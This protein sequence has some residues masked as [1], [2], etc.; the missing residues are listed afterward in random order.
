MNPSQENAQPKCIYCETE[1]A[2]TAI[3][4][5]CTKF[6]RTEGWLVFCCPVCQRTQYLSFSEGWPHPQKYPPSCLVSLGDLDGIPGPTFISTMQI[7]VPNLRLSVDEQGISIE[8]EQRVWRIAN[9]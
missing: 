3:F 5:R 7:E 6:F 2:W 9:A 8:F 1:L 4:D